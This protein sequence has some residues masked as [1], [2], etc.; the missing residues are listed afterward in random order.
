MRKIKTLLFSFFMS[1]LA[2]ALSPPVDQCYN[3]KSQYNDKYTLY[4]NLVAD[5]DRS[6]A[7]YQRQLNNVEE[8][9]NAQ[10]RSINADLSQANR[11]YSACLNKYVGKFSNSYNCAAEKNKVTALSKKL[12]AVIKENNAERSKL[13]KSHQAELRGLSDRISIVKVTLKKLQEEIVSCE[14]AFLKKQNSKISSISLQKVYK[15]SKN[16]LVLVAYVSHCSA[17]AV[18]HSEVSKGPEYCVMYSDGPGSCSGE[19][20]DVSAVI[21][22]S[23]KANTVC[24]QVVGTTRIVLGNFQENDKEFTVKLRTLGSIYDYRF[25]VGSDGSILP[26]DDIQDISPSFPMVPEVDQSL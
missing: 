15:N 14:N 13:T 10:V 3:L 17:D 23:P 19:V 22:E 26:V 2:S 8:R 9:N 11:A 24:A 1:S 20:Y 25:T 5:I 6:K 4:K 7:I 21:V 18:L 16:Q 12:A